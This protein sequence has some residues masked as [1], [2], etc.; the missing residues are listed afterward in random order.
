MNRLKGWAVTLRLFAIAMLLISCS[1]SE[2]QRYSKSDAQSDGLEVILM[3]NSA[4]FYVRDE[5]KNCFIV[6]KLQ[7]GGS[8]G[9]KTVAMATVPCDSIKEN[10]AKDSDSRSV[11]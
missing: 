9:G 4:R 8:A 10:N 7:A 3:Y 11:D 6:W 5:Y 1:E 2:L